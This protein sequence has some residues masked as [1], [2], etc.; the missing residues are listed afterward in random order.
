MKELFVFGAGASHASTNQGTPLGKDLLWTYY[1]DC[2][3]FPLIENDKPTNDSVSEELK[4]FED[5]FL[6]L[7]SRPEFIKYVNQLERNVKDGMISYFNVEKKYYVDELITIIY[8]V[9]E[10]RRMPF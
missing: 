5:L 7:R 2:V 10:S 4:C 1:P 9:R 8:C 3:L 6:F